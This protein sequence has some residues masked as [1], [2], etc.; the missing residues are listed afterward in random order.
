MEH[1]SRS[2]S[3]DFEQSTHG[4]QSTPFALSQVKMFISLNAI[5][6]FATEIQPD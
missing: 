5:K 4:I 6:S 1:K 2:E 3:R